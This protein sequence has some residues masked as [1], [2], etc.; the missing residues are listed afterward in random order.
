MWLP[1]D[2]TA[3]PVGLCNHGEGNHKAKTQNIRLLHRSLASG[4]RE[5]ASCG[6]ELTISEYGKRDSAGKRRKCVVPVD[7]FRSFFLYD[8]ILSRR[9]W[10]AHKKRG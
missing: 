4:D 8:S 9:R 3:V 5:C 2:L 10:A 6:G 1:H 7:V